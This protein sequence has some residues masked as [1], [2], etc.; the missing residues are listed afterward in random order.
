MDLVDTTRRLNR[1]WFH[2]YMLNPAALR[3]GTR[4]PQ[5]WPGGETFY[6]DILDGDTQRQIDS[7]WTY[8]SDGKLAINPE[9]LVPRNKE[10]VVAS[11][12][13]VYRN[14][15]WEAGFRGIAVGY[16]A[17]VN[18]AFDAQNKRLALL[19][20]NRFLNVTSHWSRQSMGRIR[21][22]GDDVIVLPSATPFAKLDQPDRAWPTDENKKLNIKFGGYQLDELDRP[23]F[24]YQIRDGDSTLQVQDFSDGMLDGDQFALQRQLTLSGESK[25]GEIGWLIWND[26]PVTEKAGVYQCGEKLTIHFQLPENAKAIIA[27]DQSNELRILIDPTKATTNN[28]QTKIGVRYQW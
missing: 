9:G 26:S 19:W 17:H 27:G 14:K 22:A 16:S 12:A 25:Q 8:L 6:K 28:H 4:M 23:T 18:M 15:L 1:H 5:S 7:L 2:R 13:V 3:P 11:K 24:L 10:L 20:K 21:P